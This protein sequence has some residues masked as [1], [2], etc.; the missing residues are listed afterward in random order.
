MNRNRLK[1]IDLVV[2]VLAVMLIS[3]SFYQTWLG[4]QQI[5]GPASFI[6]SLVLSTMLLILC[7]L[8]RDAKLEGSST[9]GLMTIYVF[10]ASFCFMANFNALYTRFMRTDIYTTELRDINE[11]FNLLEADVNSKFNYRYDDETKQNV[12]IL[13]KQMIEQIKELEQEHNH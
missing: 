4:L 1:P 3:V 8:L 2:G 13:K 10:I 9:A 7:W 5:F 12:E 11:N 6:I